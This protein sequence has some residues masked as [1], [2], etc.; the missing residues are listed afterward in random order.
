MSGQFLDTD[1]EAILDEINIPFQLTGK[2]VSKDCIGI[3]CPFCDDTSTHLGIFKLHKNYSCW[4]CGAKGSLPKLLKE[5]T[6]SSWP[7]IFKL[8]QTYSGSLEGLKKFGLYQEPKKVVELDSRAL[9]GIKQGLAPMHRSYILSRNLNP[10]YLEQKY[11]LMSGI[12]I[13]KYKHR[14]I[15]P[16]F[17]KKQMVSF[18]GRDITGQAK[19]RYKNLTVSQSIVPV[20]EAVYNLD[21]VNDVAILS[22]GPFDVWSFDPYGIG[23]FGIKITPMQLYKLFLKKLKKL[24]ICLDPTAQKQAKKITLETSTFIPEIKMCII[25]SGEDPAEAATHEIVD[26]KKELL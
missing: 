24:I 25:Q 15:I 14:L 1:I 4:I 19:L 11:K 5:L 6:D 9:T 22:E 12:E 13:G 18:I 7:E 2:N 10:D 3:T 20:K 23:I 17:E 16:I 26:I 21:N 8:I